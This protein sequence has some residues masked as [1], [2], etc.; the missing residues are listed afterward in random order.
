MSIDITAPTIDPRTIDEIAQDTLTTILDNDDLE[1]TEYGSASPIAQLVGMIA[2]LTKAEA[3]VAQKAVVALKQGFYYLLG[4]DMQTETYATCEATFTLEEALG[5][6]LDIPS[7]TRLATT[8]SPQIIYETTEEETISAGETEKTVTMQ[9]TRAGS[10]YRVGVDDLTVYLGS[11]PFIDYQVSNTASTGGTDSETAEEAILRMQAAVGTRG[12][13]CTT[14]QF[15]GQAEQVS[16]VYRAKCYYTTE[17]SSPSTTSPGMTTVIV[18]PDDQAGTST[19]LTEVESHFEDIRIAGFPVQF[20]L[21]SWFD[22]DVTTEVRLGS[23]SL[24]TV[25]TN[26]EEALEEAFKDWEWQE[27]VTMESVK[28]VIRGAVGVVN[29]KLTLPSSDTEIGK[30]GLPRL[31]TLTVTEWQ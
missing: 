13:A 19:L 1:I 15:E 4:L 21:P 22:I 24:A 7:G 27:P 23:S 2:L 28:S 11:T 17:Y 3:E 25:T 10:A 14:E 26:I 20:K 18:Q 16:G 29:C 6:D 30:F 9:A 12:I 8:T 5:Y 31:G